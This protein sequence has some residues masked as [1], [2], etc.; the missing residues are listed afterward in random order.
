MTARCAWANGDPLLA[1]YHDA[2]WGV[3]I[4]DSRELWET[5]MLEGFQ[6][7]LS[8]LVVLRRR[9]GFRRAFRDFDPE[10][11]ARFTEADIDRLMADPGIIRARAKI[12]AT[13]GN[14]RA[15]LAM[16][17]AGKDFSEFAWS[18]VGDAP[19]RGDGHVQ[20]STPLSLSMS[21][22]LKQRGFKFVGPVIV[23][24]WMQAVGMVDDHA[25]VCF[26]HRG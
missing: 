11:V 3:P 18:M 6:A 15:F 14:A 5:L 12:A 19:I 23:H 24:A 25:P 22:A 21:K 7:G 10:A 16:R 2:E 20:A 4:R 1:A 9:D 8:W 13:I 26:R 17:D